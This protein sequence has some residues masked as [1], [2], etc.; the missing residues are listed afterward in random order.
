MRPYLLPELRGS[1]IVA[2]A[3]ATGSKPIP[4]SQFRTLDLPLKIF[5]FSNKIPF[6]IPFLLRTQLQSDPVKSGHAAIKYVK[7][8]NF[9]KAATPH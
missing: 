4:F 8:P 3:T 2:P 5:F 9:P 6:K 7:F 1:T